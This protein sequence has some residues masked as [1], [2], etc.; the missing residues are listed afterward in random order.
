MDDGSG[1]KYLLTNHLGSVVAVTNGAARSSASNATCLRLRA[2][3]SVR[4]ACITQTGL[5]H[6]KRLMCPM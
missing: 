5:D 6:A 4:P 3:G 2:D 1:L